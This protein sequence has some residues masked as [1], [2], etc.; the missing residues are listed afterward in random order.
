[1]GPLLRKEEEQNYC[2]LERRSCSAAAA[3]SP[4][5]RSGYPPGF[6]NGVDLRL[7]VKDSK[8]AKLRG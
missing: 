1:M 7:L 4:M 2:I 8:L 5:S 6:G 3:P